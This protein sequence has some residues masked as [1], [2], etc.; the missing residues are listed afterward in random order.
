MPFPR[1]VVARF[2]KPEAVN[3]YLASDAKCGELRLM[4]EMEKAFE[5]R[6]S[7]DKKRFESQSVFEQKV[8]CAKKHVE[9][10]LLTLKC[11]RCQQAFADFSDCFALT[12]SRCSCGFC[13]WCLQ[14]CKA[15][16]HQHVANCQYN[17]A[18]NRNVYGS[19]AMFDRAQLIRRQD[20]VRRYL[21]SLG[22]HELAHAVLTALRGTLKQVGLKLDE[23]L[24]GLN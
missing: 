23:L 7:A 5:E 4:A 6:L 21:L 20:Q 17:M 8:L 16:A 13:A 15:D 14:D 19:P 10:E 9:E 12:C 2:A 22:S 24:N 11:P 18:P 1:E 3:A